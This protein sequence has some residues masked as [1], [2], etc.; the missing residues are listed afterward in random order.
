MQSG[1]RT[2]LFLAMILGAVLSSL[3]AH[4][5]TNPPGWSSSAAYAVGDQAQLGGNVYRCIKAAPAGMGAPTANYTNWEL[6]L[7]RSNTTLMLGLG[8]TF[9]TLTAAWN[10][11]LNTRVADGAYL[12]FYISSAE[13]GFYES[14]PS[15]LILDHGSG[16]RMAIIGDSTANDVLSFVG[17]GV[18]V[19]TGHSFNTIS[20]ISIECQSGGSSLTGLA[21]NSEGSISNVA[22]VSF[23]GFAT[24][25]SAS[26]NSSVNLTSN[27]ALSGFGT[28]GLKATFGGFISATS[29]SVSGAVNAAGIDSDEG[30]MIVANGANA[31]GMETSFEAERGGYLEIENA[32]ASGSQD[33][34]LKV[35]G[36]V[37]DAQGARLS[38][39]PTASF[40]IIATDEAYV[41][42]QS[43]SASSAA[44]DC[45]VNDRA[46][47]NATFASFGKSTGG[48][49][50]IASDGG[51]IDATSAK[52]NTSSQRGSVDG[53]YIYY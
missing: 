42:F 49:D 9:P 10:Y 32:T 31:T 35:D 1:S 47:V 5:Q 19:D 46:F 50:L 27:C 43:G 25:V 13:T 12:H 53:S 18:V 7:V 16:A 20:G 17:S 4:A 45:M 52:F 34:A 44:G 11:A 36:A 39:L 28:F 26:H 41:N 8:Q 24:A 38:V 51:V 21:V 48:V 6:L 22:S 30:G 15:T 33:V 3:P 29:I 23:L 2:I 40:A 37:V 14:F